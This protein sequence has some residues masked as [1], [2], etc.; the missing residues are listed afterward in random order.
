MLY[1]PSSSQATLGLRTAPTAPPRPHRNNPSLAP[2]RV[3]NDGR[4]V[5]SLPPLHGAMKPAR[6]EVPSTTTHTVPLPCCTVCRRRRS[7]TLLRAAQRRFGE[8]LRPGFFGDRRGR[9]SPR[10]SSAGASPGTRSRAGSSAHGRSRRVNS[11]TILWRLPAPSAARRTS[12]SARRP[13]RSL[14]LRITTASNCSA[15][16][17]S[18]SPIT[19]EPQPGRMAPG[20]MGE[21]WSG[22]G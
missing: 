11:E 4:G 17:S 19:M 3:G 13:A 20:H 1:A 10:C 21:R 6:T 22:T 2:F 7:A 16:N 9:S 5:V 18:S 14:H 8:S 15:S 12:S